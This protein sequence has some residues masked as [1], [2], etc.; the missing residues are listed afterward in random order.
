VPRIQPLEAGKSLS[1]SASVSS[2]AACGEKQQVRHSFKMGGPSRFQFASR[3]CRRSRQM[4]R[5]AGLVIEASVFRGHFGSGIAEAI[6][7]IASSFVPAVRRLFEGRF[8][9]T[10]IRGGGKPTA[11]A[12]RLARRGPDLPV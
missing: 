11:V 5:D 9:A 4:F 12:K 2:G 3:A 1:T 6:Q 10:G 7:E 8:G